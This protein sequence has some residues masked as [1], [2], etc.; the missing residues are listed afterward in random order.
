M[1][2]HD[3]DT[4]KRFARYIRQLKSRFVY[5]TRLPE[6]I[7]EAEKLYVGSLDLLDNPAFIKVFNLM[8]EEYKN[9]MKKAITKRGVIRAQEGLTYADNFLNE[10]H[11]FILLY[12]DLEAQRV[13]KDKSKSKQNRGE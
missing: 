3:Q 10:L 8:R 13:Q 1:S 5:G 11:N 2:Q 9:R 7:D 12:G 4:I 6:S